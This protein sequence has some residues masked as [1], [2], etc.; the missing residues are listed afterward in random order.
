MPSFKCQYPEKKKKELLCAV[1]KAKQFY[2][3]DVVF[4]LG[5][6]VRVKGTGYVFVID[7]TN[8]HRL[9]SCRNYGGVH[10]REE[11]ER[12]RNP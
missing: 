11:L 1:A 12:V 7:Q 4:K 5:D 9:Y 8:Y 6:K 2:C 10:V 3:R